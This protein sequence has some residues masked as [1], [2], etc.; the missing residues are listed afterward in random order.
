MIHDNCIAN[1]QIGRILISNDFC[2]LYTLADFQEHFGD[3]IYYCSYHIGI[4]DN[5]GYVLDCDSTP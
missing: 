1:N 5:P 2:N 3:N 4:R